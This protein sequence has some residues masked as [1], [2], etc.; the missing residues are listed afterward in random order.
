MKQLRH[1]F[2]AKKTQ[3]GDKNFSSKKEAA[4]YVK[5]QMLQKSGELLFFLDQ[6]PF[7][8][9]GNKT[10]RLDFMEFWADGNVILTEVKG[11][12]HPMGKLKIDQVEEIYNVKINI[13]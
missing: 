12:N 13:V 2:N 4:Y 1:K 11:Y 9:P 3:V 6:V 5:L 8:L 7:R 10:Y